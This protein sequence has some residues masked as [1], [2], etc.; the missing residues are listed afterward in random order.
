MIKPT[1]SH[2][3]PCERIERSSKRVGENGAKAARMVIVV[4]QRHRHE[5]RPDSTHYRVP[6]LLLTASQTI[7]TIT[8]KCQIG[9]KNLKKIFTDY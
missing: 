9:T 4:V 3:G 1:E 7:A 5:L 2:L 8:I 6:G